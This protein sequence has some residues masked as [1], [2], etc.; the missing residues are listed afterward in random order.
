MLCTLHHALKSTLSLS[1]SALS[2]EEALPV[3][4]QTLQPC[5]SLVSSAV[6]TTECFLHRGPPFDMEQDSRE[7]P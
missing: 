7:S 6:P 5:A 3:I 2:L 4:S 1:K